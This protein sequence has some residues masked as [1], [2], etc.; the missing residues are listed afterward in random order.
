MRACTAQELVNDLLGSKAMARRVLAE[1]RVCVAGSARALGGS[2]RMAAGERVVL[3]LAAPDGNEASTRHAQTPVDTP[4]QIL[5]HDR[6]ALAANKPCGLLVHSDGTG[7]PTLTDHVQAALCR[8]VHDRGWPFVPTPQ[9]VNRLDV[10][11]SGIV[12]FSLTKE[13]QPAFDALV[14]THQTTLRKY[15]LA[16]VEGTVA[17]DPFTI[18]VPIARDRHQAQR[19][20]VGQSGKSSQTR[21][22]CIDRS[23]GLSLVACRLLTG[24]RHQIRVH[25]AHLGH[26]VLGD[27]LYGTSGGPLM[28]HAHALDFVHPVTGER[29]VLR[30]E[31]PERFAKLFSCKDVDWSILD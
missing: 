19:M 9:A 8:E 14:S 24:R 2:S 31:W 3:T 28:L 13:F 27:K 10:D 7:A 15:Y 30:T 26:P 17:R 6:F 23:A 29:V 21:V 22:A 11:T 16:I 18:D 5:W 12:L 25:L 20:R 4:T 1:Q